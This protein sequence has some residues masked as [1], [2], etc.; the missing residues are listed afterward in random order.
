[1][2]WVLPGGAAEK[3][4]NP[5]QAM[6]R[7]LLEETGYKGKL[8]LVSANFTGGYQNNQRFN[9]VAT[10]CVKMQEPQLDETE[11]IDVELV[12]LKEFKQ[13]LRSEMLTDIATGYLGL[14]FLGLL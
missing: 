5:K 3:G 6:E 8:K 13:H 12:T 7:E 14:D 2:L 10:E 1:M 9:F 11:F 4:E